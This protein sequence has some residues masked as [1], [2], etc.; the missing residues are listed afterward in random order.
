RERL[1]TEN[2]HSETEHRFWH[3]LTESSLVISLPSEAEWEKAARGMDGRIYPWGDDPDPNRANYDKT[4]LNGTSTVGCFPGGA[5]PYGCEEM[6]GN[7]WEWTRSLWGEEW[8]KPTFVYPYD[9]SDGREDLK[10]PG[11][12]IRVLRGGAFCSNS[13]S[14]RCAVRDDLPPVN[15][16]D[17]YGFRVVASPLVSLNDEN[18]DL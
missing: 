6:S 3:K 9:L 2:A 11:N 15:R 5:S 8:D 14:V 18:S 10:A 16:F 17:Y 12:I 13:R 7:V 1:A 4:G